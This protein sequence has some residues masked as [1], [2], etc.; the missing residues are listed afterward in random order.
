[1]HTR[2]LHRDTNESEVKK[3]SETDREKNTQKTR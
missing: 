2:I 3:L 1:M